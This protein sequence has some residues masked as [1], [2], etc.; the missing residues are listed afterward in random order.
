MNGEPFVPLGLDALPALPGVWRALG[1]TAQDTPALEPGC[2][3]AD[4]GPVEASANPAPIASKAMCFIL[5]TPFQNSTVLGA[6]H[7]LGTCF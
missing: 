2:P 7:L 6:H 1:L 4:A 5:F 3:V